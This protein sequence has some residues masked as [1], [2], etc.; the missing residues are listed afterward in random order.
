MLK[1]LSGIHCWRSG[2]FVA[3]DVSVD[4]SSCD[5]G[6]PAIPA[7]HCFLFP[8][9]VDVHVHLRE[10]GFSYKE[11]I[12]TGTAACAR[13]GY[14]DV[15]SMPNLNPVPDSPE[16][17]A[18]LLEAIKKDACIRVHPYGSITITSSDKSRPVLVIQN[19]KDP[20]AVKE[21]IHQQVEEMKISRRIR[22]GEIATFGDDM[23]D[24]LDGE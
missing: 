10:P 17:L 9:F 16:H 3:A 2:E 14:S 19:V 1:K 5:A 21:L 24:Q 11:T 4:F 22:Y 13:G 7:D 18:P 8:G 12:A 6:V 20:A 23:D 15:C